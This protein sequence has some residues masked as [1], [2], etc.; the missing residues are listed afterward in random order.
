MFS[1]CGRALRGLPVP[2]S[3]QTHR[4]TI[5]HKFGQLAHP[6][7][8]RDL[9][10]DPPLALQIINHERAVGG[11]HGDHYA[12]DV[13]EGP[14]HDLFGGEVAT[15]GTARAASPQLIAGFDLVE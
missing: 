13:A 3:L 1:I 15:I 9:H 4:D 6:R 5:S 12:S 14:E 7:I 11:I 10:I 8:W 2:R